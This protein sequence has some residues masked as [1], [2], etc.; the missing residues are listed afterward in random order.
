MNH[1]DEVAACE[2]L[3]RRAGPTTRFRLHP[4]SIFAALCL[5]LLPSHAGALELNSATQAQLESLRGIGTA[6]SERIIQERALRAFDG[7]ADFTQRVKGFK[8]AMARRLSDAGL[9]VNGQV[10]PV[11]DEP[12]K[13]P[14]R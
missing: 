1:R 8:S 11:A 9:T 12:G 6:A 3:R 4:A 14:S 7:W 13:A 5:F 2:R 10:L